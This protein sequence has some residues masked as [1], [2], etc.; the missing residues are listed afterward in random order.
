[1]RDLHC[2]LPLFRITSAKE[3]SKRCLL[4]RWNGRF[5]RYL[6]AF[7]LDR[8]GLLAHLC[9]CKSAAC[10]LESVAALDFTWFSHMRCDDHWIKGYRTYISIRVLTGLCYYLAL[11]DAIFGS[12]CLSLAPLLYE[13]GRFFSFTCLYPRQ[14]KHL[15]IRVYRMC[16]T[17]QSRTAFRFTWLC[18]MR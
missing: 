12:L 5:F 18:G 10:T 9:V 17:I 11:S 4:T 2:Q 13:A 7:A 3:I 8:R 14:Y 6:H 1:M 16:F 15:S